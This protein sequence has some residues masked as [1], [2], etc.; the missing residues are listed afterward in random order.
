MKAN[1]RP[2]TSGPRFKSADVRERM[3]SRNYIAVWME[4]IIAPEGDPVIEYE[5]IVMVFPREVPDPVLFI[6]SERDAC[7]GHASKKGVSGKHGG[8][9]FFCLFDADRHYNFGASDSWADPLVFRTEAI[10]HMVERTGELLRP[11]GA[12]L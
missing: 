2:V 3:E 11:E 8:S 1:L 9:H 12:Y 4:N 6:T 5:F 10:I 7:Y